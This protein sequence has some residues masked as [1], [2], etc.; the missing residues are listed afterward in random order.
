MT[1]LVCGSFLNYFCLQ[2]KKK[3]VLDKKEEKGDGL[4]WLTAQVKYSQ[5][6]IKARFLCKDTSRRITQNTCLLTNALK[7][8][9]RVE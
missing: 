1:R 9:V 7:A 3:N 2:N 8:N 6:R 4:L 5:S